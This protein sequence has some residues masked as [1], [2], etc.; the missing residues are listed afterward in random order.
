M[1]WL[2]LLLGAASG[3]GGL[4]A[5]A[6][7]R[8]AID[9]IE[10]LLLFLIAAVL[11]TG[12]A[13]VRAVDRSSRVMEL[14]AAIRGGGAAPV[15]VGADRDL[16]SGPLEEDPWPEDQSG[17]RLRRVVNFA[18]AAFLAVALSLAALW[19]VVPHAK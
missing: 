13:V 3:A 5:L 8:L 17:R 6:C 11:I 16:E 10:T 19:L 2:L 9:K 14:Q 12:G 15:G 4:L 1:A 7:A 18:G